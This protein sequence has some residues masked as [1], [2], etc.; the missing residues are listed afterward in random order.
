M[1][2]ARDLKI[3]RNDLKFKNGNTVYILLSTFGPDD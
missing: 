1:F 2:Q 3:T